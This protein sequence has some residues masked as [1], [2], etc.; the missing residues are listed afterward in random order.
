MH[1]AYNIYESF[2]ITSTL[3]VL[4]NHKAFDKALKIILK[5]LPY[6][7]ANNTFR[8]LLLKY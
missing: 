1:E 7:V 3:N 6:D 4:T 5:L 2:N 8:F